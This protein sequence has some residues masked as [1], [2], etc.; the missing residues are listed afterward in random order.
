M[1]IQ[2]AYLLGFMFGMVC[3]VLWF[4]GPAVDVRWREVRNQALETQANVEAALA[5]NAQTLAEMKSTQASVEQDIAAMREFTALWNYG[6][7]D[8]AVDALTSRG[9]PVK[10]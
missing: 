1:E 10:E 3:A 4:V 9:I 7:K 6:A 2:A 5:R 8:E